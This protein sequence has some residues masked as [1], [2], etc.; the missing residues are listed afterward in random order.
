MEGA[1]TAQLEQTVSWVSSKNA[2]AKLEYVNKT[3]G[4]RKQ[5]FESLLRQYDPEPLNPNDVS[6]NHVRWLTCGM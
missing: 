5:K 1:K 2:M 6:R 3:S 4:N